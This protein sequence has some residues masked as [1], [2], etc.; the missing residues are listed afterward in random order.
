MAME[1]KEKNEKRG[2][3]CKKG[4][5]CVLS[6]STCDNYKTNAALQ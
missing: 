6:T 3:G 4:G 1:M 5:Y 2:I